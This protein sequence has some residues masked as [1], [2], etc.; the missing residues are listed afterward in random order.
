MNKFEQ[1]IQ[2]IKDYLENIDCILDDLEPEEED[3]ES[4]KN[5]DNFI[6]K[7]KEDNLYTEELE[8]FI[9]NYMKFYND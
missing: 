3:D 4:I 8:M 1:N 9:D 6:E 5:L 7:L 2:E